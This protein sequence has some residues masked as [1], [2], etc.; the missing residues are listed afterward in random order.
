M[1]KVVALGVFLCAL[2][3]FFPKGECSTVLPNEFYHGLKPAAVNNFSNS[4]F[5]KYNYQTNVKP[6]LFSNKTNKNPFWSGN[7]NVNKIGNQKVIYRNNMPYKI[8]N[9]RVIYSPSHRIKSIGN[10]PVFY[11]NGRMHKIGELP[12]VYNN[13]NEIVKIGNWGVTYNS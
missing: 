6:S 8:G 5:D 13:N 10:Q 4:N 9:K 2:C 11:H 7:K 12:V 3:L 1:K